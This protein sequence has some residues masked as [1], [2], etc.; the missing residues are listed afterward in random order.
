MKKYVFVS[1]I[2]VSLGITVCNYKNLL[3]TLEKDSC[4]DSA[5]CKQGLNINTEHGLI[6]INYD[7]CVKYGY[8]WLEE[9]KSCDMR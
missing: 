2:V 6:K 8:K 5:I 3:V 1:F 9:I 7:N 4:L